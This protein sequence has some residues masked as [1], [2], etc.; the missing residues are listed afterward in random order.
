MMI[1]SAD[2][3][4]SDRPDLRALDDKS[5]LR[6]MQATY[7]VPSL[8]AWRATELKVLR[9][10]PFEGPLLEIGCGNG[11][12][13]SLLLKKIDRG[14][15]LSPN[16]VR[17]CLATGAYSAVQCMDARAL[18]YE[19]AT[20]RT[21]FANCVIEHIPSLHQVL[22]EARRVL[23]PGGRLIA[24][25]P[26][27]SM[28]RNLLFRCKWYSRLRAKALSHVNLL[29]EQEWRDAFANA[30]LG[31]IQ[32][33]P[34]ASGPFCH[35]WDIVDGVMCA[36]LGRFTVAQAYKRALRLVPCS[37]RRMIDAIWHRWFLPVLGSDPSLETAAML[38][39]GSA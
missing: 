9:H 30:G 20:F 21:V 35:R 28:N 1:A 36:G 12:F 18:E 17:L 5:L 11:R 3:Q 10:L 33:V 29:N 27:R 24:T 34:Y 37:G 6:L 23:V 2:I 16:E 13:S 25:V 32:T 15:D 26:L 31:H 38:V 14:I 19:S 8:A 7:D 22:Q 4:R 39:I